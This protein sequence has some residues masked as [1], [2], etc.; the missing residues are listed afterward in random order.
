MSL[1]TK[2]HEIASWFAKTKY[3]KKYIG[4]RII[5]SRTTSSAC[6]IIW[7]VVRLFWR[8][9]TLF[10]KNKISSYEISYSLHKLDYSYNQATLNKIKKCSTIVTPNTPGNNWVFMLVFIVGT[11]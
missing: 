10:D 9:F 6:V 4:K 2:L 5:L 11:N 3:S 7:I 8:G 1:A